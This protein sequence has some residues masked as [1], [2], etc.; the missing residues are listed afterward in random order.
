VDISYS[1]NKVK[2]VALL[3]ERVIDYSIFKVVYSLLRMLKKSNNLKYEFI[4]LDLNYQ[5][6]GGSREKAVEK[7]KSLGFEYIDC[8]KYTIN[9]I[10]PFFSYIEKCLNLRELIIKK[11]IDI[12]IGFNM[13][14]EYNFLFT[15]RT[16]PKQIYWSHGNSEYDIKGID[17]KVSHFNQKS[18]NNKFD[19]F[20][21]IG[22][23]SVSKQE[24]FS[25]VEQSEIVRNVFPKDF[26]ILGSIGRLIKI[27]NKEYLDTVLKILKENPK[28]VYI[29][30]GDGD[31]SNIEQFIKNNSIEERFLLAG[32]V[33]IQVYGRVIDIYLNTFP[34]PGGES[35]NEFVSLDENKYVVSLTD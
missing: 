22:D 10:G 29:A 26:V 24:K 3:L 21:V 28:T 33:N 16:A 15:T 17:K 5:L 9:A 20:S 12:L 35:V 14:P 1:K 30:C 25:Y 18:N 8:H 6:Y 19:F 13:Q 31:T 2:K 27:D 32:F 7:I 4:I 11:N 34:E 23:Y